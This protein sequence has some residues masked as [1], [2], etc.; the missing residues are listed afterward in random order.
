MA[1]LGDML[2]LGEVRPDLNTSLFMID[3]NH[4]SMWSPMRHVPTNGA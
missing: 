4:D 1:V 2:S 3:L